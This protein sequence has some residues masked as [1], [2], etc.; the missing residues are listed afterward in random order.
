MNIV[1]TLRRA[2]D[3]TK[4]SL[5]RIEHKDLYSQQCTA[6]DSLTIMEE[7][8]KK[9]SVAHRLSIEELL[10]GATRLVLKEKLI[11]TKRSQTTSF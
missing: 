2:Y 7:R 5:L 9:Y 11:P 10:A 4:D 3:P 8:I 1:I 6:R